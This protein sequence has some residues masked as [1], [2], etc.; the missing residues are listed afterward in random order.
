MRGFEALRA[1][2]EPAL[3][4]APETSLVAAAAGEAG[5]LERGPGRLE[6]RGAAVRR[7]R[8]DRGDD[9]QRRRAPARP[10]GRSSPRSAPS[11]S[12]SPTRSRSRSGWSRR[13]PWSTATRRARVELAG[14][15]IAARRARDRLD[16]GRRTATRR[17]SPSRTRF[18]VRR[19]NAKLHA[20]FA[21]GPHV[22]IGMHLARLE[23]HTAVARV[24]E[25]L[26]GPAPG[27]RPR[28][29]R[30]R[31]RV[32]QAGRA[33]RALDAARRRGL[34]SQPCS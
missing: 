23:A 30:A 4:R 24:L 14:A 7:D 8:D 27:G 11:R 21:A 16:R 10:P 3:A 33:A 34:G 12:C 17:C 2:M 26:P 25:R 19:P 20:A 5:G 13:P 6:R 32:P 1:A 29:G 9:R 18:D 15:P 28:A 22:C 31:A